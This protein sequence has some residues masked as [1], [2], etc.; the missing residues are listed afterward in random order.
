[1]VIYDW[2]NCLSKKK[3]TIKVD[4]IFL[5]LD[6]V[7]EEDS[8][9]DLAAEFELDEEGPRRRKSMKR[10]YFSK[11]KYCVCS[12]KRQNGDEAEVTKRMLRTILMTLLRMSKMNSL[13]QGNVVDADQARRTGNWP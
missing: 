5:A 8:E 2:Y 12:K 7:M 11:G 9:D 10:P 6:D 4:S 1:M 3:E 13:I